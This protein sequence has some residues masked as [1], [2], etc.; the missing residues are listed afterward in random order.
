M[1]KL[2]LE[3]WKEK[4]S[5]Y[6]KENNNDPQN[7]VKI[8][9]SS[10]SIVTFEKSFIY[11]G[12]VLL[13]LECLRS[14]RLVVPWSRKKIWLFP[15]VHLHIHSLWWNML[16]NM[17]PKWCPTKGGKKSPNPLAHQNPLTNCSTKPTYLINGQMGASPIRPN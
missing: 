11:F 9:I 17:H 12:I 5:T 6:I 13:S 3:K 16:W 14:T 4:L 10:L 2:Y 7:F 15:I 1:N 8:P